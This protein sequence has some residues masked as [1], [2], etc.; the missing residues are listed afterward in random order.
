MDILKIAAD[1]ATF[2]LNSPY[3]ADRVWDQLP[4]EV[5]QQIIDKRLRFFVVDGHEVA[6]QTG[7]GGAYQYA[8]ANAASLHS[9]ASAA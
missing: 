1:G 9:P 3:P 7:M 6:R 2:L 8:D 4:R 5:Q